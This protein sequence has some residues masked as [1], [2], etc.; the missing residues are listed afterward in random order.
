MS[1][2]KHDRHVA[3]SAPEPPK[4]P[5]AVARVSVNHEGRGGTAPDPLVWDQ[6]SKPKVRKL[7]VR[8]NVDLASLPWPTGFF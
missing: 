6:G 2:D 5:D 7:A 1:M 4:P 3:T 8:V